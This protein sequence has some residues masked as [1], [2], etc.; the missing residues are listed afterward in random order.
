MELEDEKKYSAAYLAEKQK[1]KE[2]EL[3]LKERENKQREHLK[4]RK[5]K[6]KDDPEGLFYVFQMCGAGV[7]VQLEGFF[8]RRFIVKEYAPEYKSVDN[9]LRYVV[10][11]DPGEYVYAMQSSQYKMLRSDNAEGDKYR[12]TIFEA[13]EN[14]LKIFEYC[15]NNKISRFNFTTKMNPDYMT[16]YDHEVKKF[17]KDL[18]EEK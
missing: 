2:A 1:E 8:D 13:Y 15:R 18:K 6:I 9:V 10:F 5:E 16:L 17:F 4:E 14:A 3:K 11:P 7:A 12:Q